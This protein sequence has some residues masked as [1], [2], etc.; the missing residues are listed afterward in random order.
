MTN[1]N[2]QQK[3]LVSLIFFCALGIKPT[4]RAQG[5]LPPVR[6]EPFDATE[7]RHTALALSSSL[8][9]KENSMMAM[10]DSVKPGMISCRSN[11]P[12]D[13]CFQMTTVIPLARIP[14]SAPIRFILFQYSERSRVGPRAAPNPAQA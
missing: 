2:F 3:L 10:L 12:P 1:R 5:Q 9:I 14:A 7:I 4:Q 11:I 6:T 13:S 8:L